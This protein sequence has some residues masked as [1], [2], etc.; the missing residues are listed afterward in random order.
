M[1]EGSDKASVQAR[2]GRAGLR[3]ILAANAA[4]LAMAI[5]QDWP[6]AFLMW[7][8]WIQSMVIGWFARERIL[9][10]RSYAEGGFLLDGRSATAPPRTQRQYA[11]LLVLHY[12]LAHVLYLAVMI[13]TLPAIGARDW[14]LFALGGAGF[15]LAHRHSHRL[16][17]AADTHAVHRIGALV[18]LPY[19]RV[20]PMH[21]CIVL[22][23]SAMVP[24][25][26]VALISFTVLKIAADAFMHV[27]EHRWLQR[28]ARV[29]GQ[30]PKEERRR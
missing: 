2:P 5:W 11:N 12:G 28:G 3:A 18:F 27:A 21:L 6:L 14:A 17:V 13:E 9:A 23:T 25:S 16:N 24:A 26:W 10:L 22:A 29:A 8:Y 4:T 20:V 30:P 19:V 7:P 15:W 1:T